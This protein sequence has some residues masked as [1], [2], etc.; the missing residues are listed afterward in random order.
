MTHWTISLSPVPTVAGWG[1]EGDNLE[2]WTYGIEI[3]NQLDS[4]A[5]PRLK[6]ITCMLMAHEN[7]SSD[8]R[9]PSV[10][11]VAYTDWFILVKEPNSQFPCASLTPESMWLHF[12]ICFHDI[13]CL[14]FYSHHHVC[15]YIFNLGI[16]S[17][18]YTPQDKNHADLS[19]A[20]SL[21]HSTV[22]GM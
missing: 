3:R 17:E 4:E 1:G 8:H 18:S 21:V 2:G 5:R 10:W 16:P 7:S 14:S 12:W 15:D 19:A 6:H 9:K 20:R 11:E 22:P 13:S